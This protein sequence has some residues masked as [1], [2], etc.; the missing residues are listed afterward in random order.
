MIF[1]SNGWKRA[2]SIVLFITAKIPQLAP[3]QPLLEAIASVLGVIGV[4]HAAA[5]H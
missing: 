4:A 3:Y 1:Q 2:F 5:S